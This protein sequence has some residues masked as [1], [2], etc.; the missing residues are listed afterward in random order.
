MNLLQSLDSPEPF[1]VTLNGTNVV[2]PEKMLRRI[3]YDHPVYT[4]ASRLRRSAR[5]PEIQGQRTDLVCRRV[6]GLGLP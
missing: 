1:I 2:D 6:L 4:H 3:R 5:K